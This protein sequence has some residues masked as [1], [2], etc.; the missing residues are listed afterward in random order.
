MLAGPGP[1]EA[2][3][4]VP[5]EAFARTE[6]REDPADSRPRVRVRLG[7]IDVDVVEFGEVVDLVAVPADPRV[8]ARTITTANIQHM[9]LA[10]RD[11]QM[12][13]L[14]GAS[15]LTIAD[16]WPVARLAGWV[17]GMP[18]RR[19]AGSDLLPALLATAASRGLGVALI[20]AREGA[21]EAVAR[22]H[23]SRYPG[24][25][26]MAMEPHISD[27]P[28]DAEVTEVISALSGGSWDL[29]V[30]ALGSPKS[31]RFAGRL[32]TTLDAGTIIGVGAGIDF[33]AGRIRRAPAFLQRAG[34]EWLWRM[35]RE[36]VRLTPRYASATMDMLP[37][38]LGAVR[39]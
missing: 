29:V 22:R 18:C 23:R 6:V 27:V 12:R 19:L 11:P 25:R 2:A 1:V 31:E 20:G 5:Q 26:V 30:L 21:A 15:A 13:A 39:R 9:A 14:I 17:S 32:A 37:V 33:L 7:E 16:G 36:P 34:L 38:V 28:T 8:G 10:R 35:V 24:A 3:A 4:S